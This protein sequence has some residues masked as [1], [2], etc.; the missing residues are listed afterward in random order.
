M[1]SVIWIYLTNSFA[2]LS[3]CGL[4]VFSGHYQVPSPS[5]VFCMR[6]HENRE[7][8]FLSLRLDFPR[9]CRIKR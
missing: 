6:E 4:A 1:S 3:R 5:G 9:G 7:F 8:W 2:M